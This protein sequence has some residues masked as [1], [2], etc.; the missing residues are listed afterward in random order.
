MSRPDHDRRLSQSATASAPFLSLIIPAYNEV[1]RIVPTLDA[2][3]TYLDQQPWAYD[4]QIVADGDD[5][6]RERAAIWAAG[7][8]RVAVL[9]DS[10]R[11]GKGRAVRNGVMRATGE[12]VGFIDADYKTPIE[13][14]GKLL[15]WFGAGYD[16]AV[17]SRKLRD[18]EVER[19][20]PIH[21]RLG[22]RAFGVVLR[23]LIELPAVRDTQCGFKFFR[24][25]VARRIFS[26][27]RVDGYMFD[28]EVLRLTAL[29]GYRV[30]EVGVRWRDDGD[31]R[32]HPLWGTLH[33]AR[34]IFRI[35][36]MRYDLAA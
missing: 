21:R 11:H 19:P 4:I 10:G 29:L 20:Q 36:R 18:A 33:N 32:Y 1:E 24:R 9:G 30:C 5:G 22:S 15:P 8:P 6:T 28:V 26:L 25:D 16:V 31:S 34:E 14:L 3:R 23:R 17:G 7:D 27:Q 2:V 35:R 12:I 13:E